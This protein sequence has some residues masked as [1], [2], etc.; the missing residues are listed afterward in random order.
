[1]ISNATH[2]GRTMGRTM[3]APWGAC[4]CR[5]LPAATFGL[6][7]AFINTEPS[8]IL[9]PTLRHLALCIRRR[10]SG[11]RF[12][13]AP[14]HTRTIRRVPATARADT[15]VL[16]DAIVPALESVK[17]CNPALTI[18][19]RLRSRRRRHRLRCRR[20][21]CRRRCTAVIGED[22]DISAMQP[23]LPGLLTIPT[24]A[25]ESVLARKVV[26]KLHF[27]L[28]EC[29]TT[30]VAM[31]CSMLALCHAPATTFLCAI[32]W[33]AMEPRTCFHTA[34][35]R[36]A[37]RM[38]I[39]MLAWNIITGQDTPLKACLQCRVVIFIGRVIRVDVLRNNAFIS[40]QT[41]RVR[42]AMISRI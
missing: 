20:P 29:A 37:R 30:I 12:R 6:A 40:A 2:N 21:R 36:L 28:E 11:I 10:H 7:G 32:V 22:G 34:H 14:R 41:V 5:L 3:E 19:G 39:T 18:L 23:E 26:W 33:I 4:L 25:N 38:H 27:I 35:T 8:T 16:V 24:E 31:A 17:L 1:M 15:V 9:P 13:I 42:T